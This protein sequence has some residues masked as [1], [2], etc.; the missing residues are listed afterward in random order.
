MYGGVL[1]EI[2]YNMEYKLR[3]FQSLR[4]IMEYVSYVRF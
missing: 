3:G 4:Q 2:H 1:A